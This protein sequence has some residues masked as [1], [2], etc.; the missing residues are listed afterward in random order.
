MVTSY[1]GQAASV[2]ELDMA[3]YNFAMKLIY[4]GLWDRLREG[5]YMV[6]VTQDFIRKRKRVTVSNYNIQMALQAGFGPP[7]EWH[8][9]TSPGGYGAIV[10][11]KERAKLMEEGKIAV[12]EE[13]VNEDAIVFRKEAR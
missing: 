9:R 4:K 7:I 1:G 2:G 11:R 12:V 3:N 5:G 8:T 13:N 6:T 10:E